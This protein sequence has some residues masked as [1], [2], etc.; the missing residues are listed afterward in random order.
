MVAKLLFSVAF[1]HLLVSAG[2]TKE[3]EQTNHE[4][5]QPADREAG[6]HGHQTCSRCRH[7]AKKRHAQRH[8]SHD[9]LST[10]VPLHTL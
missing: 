1:L 6:R 8:L 3:K 4:W 9:T 10:L 7:T 5:T 2:E